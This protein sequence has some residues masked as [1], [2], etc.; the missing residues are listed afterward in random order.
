MVPQ[1]DGCSVPMALLY[2]DERGVWGVQG[3]V[4]G[5]DGWTVLPAPVDDL[6]N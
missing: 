5:A 1:W 2:G 4:V 3:V 6:L